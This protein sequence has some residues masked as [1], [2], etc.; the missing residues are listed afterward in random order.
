MLLSG[1]FFSQSFCIINYAC[2][3][4][5]KR[6]FENEQNVWSLTSQRQIYYEFS[7]YYAIFSPKF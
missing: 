7:K 5:Q 1:V 4:H 6:A 3:L 2:V